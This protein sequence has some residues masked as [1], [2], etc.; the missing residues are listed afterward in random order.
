MMCQNVFGCWVVVGI[1]IPTVCFFKNFG[2]GILSAD[3][4]MSLKWNDPRYSWEPG[5]NYFLYYIGCIFLPAFG[6]CALQTLV[7]NLLFQLFLCLKAE[8]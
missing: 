6:C 2:T 4:W 8:K 3:G 1:L 5:T 7:K